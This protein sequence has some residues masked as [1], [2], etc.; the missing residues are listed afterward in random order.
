[1]NMSRRKRVFTIVLITTIVFGLLGCRS[2]EEEVWGGTRPPTDITES[3]ETEPPRDHMELALDMVQHSFSDDRDYMLLFDEWEENETVAELIRKTKDHPIELD[4]VY[5][6][7]YAIAAE[8]PFELPSNDS[9]M[10]VYPNDVVLFEGN[11]IMICYA[12]HTGN[13]T[14]L[15]HGKDQAG[16]MYA[17]GVSQFYKEVIEAHPGKMKIMSYYA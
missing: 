16:E 8:L 11:K 5:M 9:E 14:L 4:L 3:S 15:T 1:M 17:G 13:Y 7:D 12:K 6:D 2:Q 10:T